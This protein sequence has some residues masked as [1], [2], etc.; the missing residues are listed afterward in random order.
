MESQKITCRLC[1]IESIVVGLLFSVTAINY[2][3]R[4]TLSVVA[5]L[6]GKQLSLSTTGYA[7]VVFLFLLGYT[8]GQTLDGKVIDKIGTRLGMLS[9]VASW[10]VISILQSLVAGAASLGIL[11]FLLGTAEAGNWPGGVKAVAENFAP[12]QRAFAIGVF[13]SGSTAGAI[14]AP[15]LVAAIVGVWG[16]R[17]MFAAIGG[18]GLVW[19]FLWSKLYRTEPAR[20]RGI[21][22][23]PAPARSP[24]STLLRDRA[25]WALMVGRFLADPIWW[26]YAFWLPEYLA[27]G[28]GFSIASIGRTAWIPFAFAGIGGWVGGLASDR[29]VRRRLVPVTARKAVTVVGALLML[30]G[31]PA[32]RARTSAAALTFI[33][34]VLLG[35]TGW[36]SNILSL[37][38]DLF[39]THEVAQVTGLSGT[40][41]AV[42][43]MLFTLATGWLVQNVSYGAVFIA[44]SGMIICAVTVIIGLVPRSR[45]LVN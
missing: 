17:L 13:N 21:P 23:S 2:L 25:V 35:Y 31:I 19:I 11:R 37:V 1:S 16:W 18:I 42:G 29:L 32:F 45:V 43:G 8:V 20:A 36:A 26:F 7:R 14:I 10:S 34:V 3:D 27:Q 33:S 41:G 6:L 44:A 28:R 22:V 30:F 24:M 38:A 9:C 12:E 5:P 39:H 40:S 4:Q 15:P